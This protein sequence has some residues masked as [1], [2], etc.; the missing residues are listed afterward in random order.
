MARAV[1]T[2]EIAVSADDLYALLADFGDVGWMKGVTKVEV[3]GEGPG[4][5]R[6]IYAG[7]PESVVE[8]LESLEP[9]ARRVGYTITKNN[10]LPVADYHATCTAVELGPARCRLE[11]AC[12][13][14]PKGA[15]QA[16]AIAAV[17]GMYGVL[18]SWVK[19]ALEA[20]GS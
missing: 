12:D 4:M 6:F 20:G 9:A 18:I 13:F 15:E 17:Q 3:R 10:P 19:E 16:A 7:G 14:T 8:V 1:A 2:G 5:T 11:W